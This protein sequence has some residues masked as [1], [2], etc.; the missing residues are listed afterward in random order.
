M[1]GTNTLEREVVLHRYYDPN[2]G[3]FLSVDPLLDL[4]GTP[5]VYTSGDPVNLTDATGLD[6][7]G[8]LFDSFNPWSQNNVLY[9]FGY[10]H[11]LGGKV[12]VAGSG[13]GIA[14]ASCYIACPALAIAG[15]ADEESNPNAFSGFFDQCRAFFGD[16]TG[17]IGGSDSEQTVDEVLKGKVGSITRAPLPA[18]SPSWDEL[19]SMTMSEI[20]KGAKT[21]LPGYRTILK[22]LTNSRYNK[23]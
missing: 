17:A 19:R 12:V 3:Q 4:T 14:A 2:A 8:A 22:L 9:R 15:A 18:G 21:N 13:V 16:E 5:Y 6:F 20:E 10:H 23:P 7:L 11:P 1:T